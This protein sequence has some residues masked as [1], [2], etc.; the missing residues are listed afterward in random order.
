VGENGRLSLKI[1]TARGAA[2]SYHQAVSHIG[3][4]LGFGKLHADLSDDQMYAGELRLAELADQLGFDSLWAVEHHFDDYAMCPDNVVLL[5]NV[6]G[7]TERVKLG[8]GAVILPWNDPLRVAEKMIM[9]DILSGG[10]VLFG[11]GRGLSR[12]EY[13]PFG[14]PMSESRAR[15]DEAA[16]MIAKALETGWIEGDGPYYPRPRTQLR[17][18]PP[19]SF[20][21]RL[22]C[23]AGS[24]DSVTSCARLGA[25]LLTIVTQP[26][27]NLMPVFASYREQYETAH[28]GQ[29][30]PIALNVNMYCHTDAEVARERALL[31]VHRFFASNVRHYEFTGEHFARTEGYQRYDEIA[32]VFR[33]IGVEAAADAYA[34]CALIG[35]PDQVLQ[36][37]ADIGDVLG[38]YEL[39]VLPS[40]GGMPYDQ[41]EHSLELFAKEVMPGAR[42]LQG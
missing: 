30:P 42:E 8:T 14:V 24:P 22:Y 32:R 40:F 21:G 39:T 6:A 15:F 26:V 13:A 29:A 35:T 17:P 2:R 34:A 36:K 19:R 23:V 27:A 18:S 33:A 9:L 25:S 28:G 12:M 1:E 3:V 31:Y 37:I 5:A 41:A 20:A 7:R 38:N 16:A 11:M 4:N 10:R